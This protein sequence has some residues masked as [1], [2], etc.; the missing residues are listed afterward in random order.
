M[1]AIQAILNA[2]IV[3]TVLETIRG[4]TVHM[5]TPRFMKALKSNVPWTNRSSSNSLLRV[6]GH[7]LS[8]LPLVDLITGPVWCHLEVLSRVFVIELSL[9][10]IS[11]LVFNKNSRFS[12]SRILMHINSSMT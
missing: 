1:Q 11:A 3:Q 6:M 5:E 12:S 9:G 8:P 4:T 7:A 10:K 2:R